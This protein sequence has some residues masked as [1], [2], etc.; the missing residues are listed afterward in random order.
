MKTFIAIN[1]K[2]FYMMTKNDILYLYFVD[3][4]EEAGFWSVDK[5]NFQ[6]NDDNSIRV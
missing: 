5:G 2:S 4:N 6:F 3:T 1:G